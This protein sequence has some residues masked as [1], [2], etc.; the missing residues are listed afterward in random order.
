[1]VSAV[2]KNTKDWIKAISLIPVVLLS[3]LIIGIIAF[4]L[5]LPFIY[6]SGQA[7]R[8]Q[9]RNE[10]FA[11]VLEN[12]DSIE[13]INPNFQQDF[14]YTATGLQDG[15]VEYGYYYEPDDV[16]TL[17][18]EPYR[19]GYRTYGVPDDDTDWYYSERICENWFYYEIH[20]G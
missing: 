20:D 10:I 18:G 11:Y 19:G 3:P 13:L 6:I 16:H 14:F 12:R 8:N 5:P 17:R 4:L 9:I 2:K 1:M 7:E 15:G